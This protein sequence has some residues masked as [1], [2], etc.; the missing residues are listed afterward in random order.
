VKYAFIDEHSEEF[1]V[2][3]MCRVMGV[4]KSG[5]FAWCKRDESPREA[6]KNAL[7]VKIAQIHQG[8]RSTYGSP[9]VYRVL[10]GMGEK[11]SKG[12]VERLMRKHGIRSKVRRK[13]KAT[14]DSNHPLPVAPNRVR[15]DFTAPAP[16]R[17]WVT[18]ITYLWTDEGWLYLSAIVDVFTRKV[19]GW[20]MKDRLTLPLVTE[21]LEMAIRRQRPQSGLV[22]HSDRGCQY[23][24]HEYRKALRGYGMVASMSRR[25]Q[26]WDNALMESFF[27]TLKTEHVYHESFTTRTEARNSVFEWIEVFYNRQRIHSALGYVSPECYERRA[28]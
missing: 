2:G 25:G 9:R 16:N 23:A 8:S 28:A 3:L 17:L 27:H 20:A 18:D 15:R 12:T 10:K 7:V 1:P 4:S 24:A 26:C 14:T 6:R 19:V 5:Y 22:H 11:C 21:A 13:Y